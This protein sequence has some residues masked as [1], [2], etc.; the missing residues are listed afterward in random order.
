[1]DA[2]T[3]QRKL[4]RAR[5]E[6]AKLNAQLA[7]ARRKKRDEDRTRAGISLEICRFGLDREE[8]HIGC[9]LYAMEAMQE[10]PDLE[11]QF[12]AAGAACISAARIAREGANNDRQTSGNL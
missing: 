7:Q 8:L 3:A 1:M 4:E 9:M 5:N 11:E 12:R 2:E 6:V 10:R